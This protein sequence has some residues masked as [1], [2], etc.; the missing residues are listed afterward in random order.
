MDVRC[1]NKCRVTK[2]VADFYA[3]SSCR[4]GIATRCKECVRA[5]QRGNPK[6][7]ARKRAYRESHRAEIA[8]GK[9]EWYLRT[10]K[11]TDKIRSRNYRGRYDLTADEYGKIFTAQNGCCAICSIQVETGPGKGGARIDHCHATGAV[12]GILCHKCNIGLGWFRDN[13]DALEN[14]ATYIRNSV[15]L[16]LVESA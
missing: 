10:V 9:R 2:P 16:R 3:A 11:G 13:A 6:R 14:A 8:S 15:R 4:D 1:C 5:Q 12:R 7:L